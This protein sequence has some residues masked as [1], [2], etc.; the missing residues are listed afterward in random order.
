[1]S[2]IP[3]DKDLRFLTADQ[4]A[5]YAIC[6]KRGHTETGNTVT[7]ERQIY[8]FCK[9]CSIAFRVVVTR[10]TQE[11]YLDPAL[12]RPVGTH[13]HVHGDGKPHHH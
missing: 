10:T 1:M 3:T 4:K 5:E 8:Q 2:T 6:R 13:L 11:V 7:V 12:V 9:Y